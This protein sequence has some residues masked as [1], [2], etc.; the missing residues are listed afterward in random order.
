MNARDPRID[1]QPGDLIQQSSGLK[2]RVTGRD[3][4]T[5][6]F[7]TKGNRGLRDRNS[8]TLLG[9]KRM[10]AANAKVLERGAPK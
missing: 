6:S 10:V 9:W 4:D 3:G 5:V 7:A 2:V 1:P 8:W